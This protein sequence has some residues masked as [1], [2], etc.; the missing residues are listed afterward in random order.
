MAVRTIVKRVYKNGM[1]KYLPEGQADVDTAK[2]LEKD[3]LIREESD[4]WTVL[5]ANNLRV[6]C[7]QLG[8]NE[9]ARAQGL[10]DAFPGIDARLLNVVKE[11]K[12]RQ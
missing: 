11:H 2:T 3:G 8:M 5:D 1:V 12:T 7:W 10:G 4:G 9:N 6:V